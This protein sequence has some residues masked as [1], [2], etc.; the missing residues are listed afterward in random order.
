MTA[1]TVAGWVAAVSGVLLLVGMLAA[2]LA[3]RAAFTNPTGGWQG[4]MGPAMMGARHMGPGMMQGFG[5]SSTSGGPPIGG[6]PEARVGAANFSFNPA[7]IRLPAN[8]PVNL[9]LANPTAVV[10]DLTVPALGI[11]VVAGPGQ[12][13]TVGLRGLPAGRYPAFCSVPGHADAGMRA[14]IVVE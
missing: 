4:I 8:A 9:T 1:R 7:E 5:Q 2:T 12:T 6:A 3:A 13:S 10:H 14:T 11:Q